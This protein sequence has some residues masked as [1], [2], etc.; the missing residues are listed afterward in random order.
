MRGRMLSMCRGALVGD[1]NICHAVF[2]RDAMAQTG[3][4]IKGLAA[5]TD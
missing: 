2:Q 1:T 5:V 3:K 4:R